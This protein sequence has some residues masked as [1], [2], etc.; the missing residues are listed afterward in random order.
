MT[1]Y[2]TTYGWRS[3]GVRRD[4]VTSPPEQNPVNGGRR[5]RTGVYEI[6][7]PITTN[8]KAAG[9]SPAE[10]AISF[11]LF[12]GKTEVQRK[13]QRIF[14]PFLVPTRQD[15]TL[16]RADTAWSCISNST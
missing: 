14:W 16:S 5:G 10:R 1:T 4:L 11:L 7:D 13:G 3:T 9:S 6:A 8:Q 15:K 12:A 2:A